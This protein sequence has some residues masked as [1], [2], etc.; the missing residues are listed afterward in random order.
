M[1]KIDR[2]K[3]ECRDRIAYCESQNM[4][5]FE[6]FAARALLLVIQEVESDWEHLPLRYKSEVTLKKL[7]ELYDC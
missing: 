7:E 5:P 6:L 2:I 4:Q 1:T 3:Q